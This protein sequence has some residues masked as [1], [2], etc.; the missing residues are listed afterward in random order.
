MTP[1]DTEPFSVQ[2][3]EY[4]RLEA[5]VMSGGEI[6]IK[7]KG[8]AKV[9]SENYLSQRIEGQEPVGAY[10]KEFELRPTG[11]GEVRATII[12]ELPMPEA[13]PKKITYRFEVR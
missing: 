9:V 8:P 13:K 3:D 10:K 4:V 6:T 1:L 12:V 11:K 2:T 7:I 5:E